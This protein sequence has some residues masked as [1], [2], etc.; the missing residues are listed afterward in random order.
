MS[1]LLRLVEA[2]KKGAVVCATCSFF[3]AEID[4]CAKGKS[5]VWLPVAASSAIGVDKECYKAGVKILNPTTH[6]C[7]MWER[8]GAP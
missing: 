1:I 3:D 7:S 6:F 4:V 2:S 8:T 5:E